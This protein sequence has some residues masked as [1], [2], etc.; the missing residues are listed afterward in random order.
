MAFH[1]LRVVCG[2]VIGPLLLFPLSK[3]AVTTKPESQWAD[4]EFLLMCLLD[5][6]LNIII[7]PLESPTP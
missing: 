3:T 7:V 6:I 4:L 1:L 5:K 2:N